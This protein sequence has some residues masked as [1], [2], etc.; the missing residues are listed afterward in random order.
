M[1]FLF[2]INKVIRYVSSIAYNHAVFISYLYEHFFLFKRA[3]AFFS[4]VSLI[5]SHSRVTPCASKITYYQLG[6]IL[7]GENVFFFWRI[8]NDEMYVHF[9]E[10]ISYKLS[11]DLCDYTV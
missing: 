10:T 6:I 5:F 8:L 9:I 11:G 1:Q 4:L 2:I 3:V 7:L